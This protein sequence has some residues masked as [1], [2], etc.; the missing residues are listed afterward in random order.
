MADPKYADLPGIVSTGPGP[1]PQTA[2]PISQGPPRETNPRPLPLAAPSPP[3]GF[4]PL[5]LRRL[6]HLLDCRPDWAGPLDSASGP[7]LAVAGF[8]A[9]KS[10]PGAYHLCPSVCIIHVNTALVAPNFPIAYPR[11][12]TPAVLTRPLDDGFHLARE[13]VTVAE[14]LCQ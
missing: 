2:P 14:T 11:I 7:F 10:P 9:Q 4:S 3:Q 8:S 13:E 12:L 1:A 6:Q 5:A